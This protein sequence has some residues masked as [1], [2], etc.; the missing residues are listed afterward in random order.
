[1][2]RKLLKSSIIALTILIIAGC[3]KNRMTKVFTA[4]MVQ[5]VNNLN[6]E[7]K[8]FIKGNE[9]RM[10]INEKGE[11]ISIVVNRESGKQKIII[12]SGKTAQEVLNNS[13]R[14]LSNNPFESFYYALEENSSRE[15]G[16]EVINGFKCEKIEVYSEDKI[17]IT[18]WIS[19]SLDLPIKIKTAMAP[20]KEV[21]LSNIKEETIEGN[22]FQVPEDYRFT[23]VPE[24]KTRKT[25]SKEEPI[26][27]N[28]IKQIAL[29]KIE[30]K[31]IELENEDGKIKLRRIIISNLARYFPEWYF[32][33]VNREKKL[34]DEI[35][36]S[37]TP[38]EKAAIYKDKKTVCLIET[39]ET[40]MSLDKTLKT[41]LH[42][43][44]RLNKEETI[45]DFGRALVMLYFRNE[46]VQGVELT[47]KNEWAFY[48]GTASGYLKGFIVKLN[49]K[50][51]ILELNYKLKIKE[52]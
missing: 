39:P 26:N 45:K 5:K 15:K 33:R 30:E 52:Q 19:D 29:K 47:G 28:E 37:K 14:S 18:A 20:S 40:D 9:Y 41:L 24:P 21:E 8:I 11:D 25:K 16:T 2:R 13:R 32:F 27:I 46:T 49:N 50:G 1:M 42:K 31:G 34:Q 51:E 48:D 38:L 10:D 44:V 12:H 43:D 6:I 4:D 17:L 36:L 35:S 7:G 3:H 23:P 22:I